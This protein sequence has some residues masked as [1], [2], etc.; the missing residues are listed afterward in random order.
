MDYSYCENPNS[1]SENKEVET[2][3]CY[4]IDNL[5]VGNNYISFL[6]Y[7]FLNNKINNIQIS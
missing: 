4:K 1:N 6:L 5:K 2:P 7:P 3:Y